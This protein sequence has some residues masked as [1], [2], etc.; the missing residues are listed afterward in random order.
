M[1]V[2]AGLYKGRILKTVKDLSVRPATDRVKQTIFDML[3]TRIDLRGA[4]VLDL[5]AGSGSLGI[6]ALS[7]G[8]AHVTFVESDE[9]AV[10]YIEQNV[11]TLGCEMMTEI[12]ETDAMYFLLHVRSPFD[13]IFA[14]PPY[15]FER[16]AEIPDIVIERKLLKSEGYLLIEHAAGVHF[17]STQLYHAGPEKKFGRTRVTF[18]QPLPDST[19]PT[20]HS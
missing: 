19:T 10:Q 16:T 9:H 2:I 13:L 7:R 14:D 4:R 17:A 12:D 20:D 6:E 1:R 11:Q 15:A 3:A 8:A 5:F 18:I